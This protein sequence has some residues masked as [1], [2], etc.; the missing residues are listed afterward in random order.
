MH[1]STYSMWKFRV[2]W[3]NTRIT[4]LQII[5]YLLNLSIC[6]YN[7]Y[8][9]VQKLKSCGNVKI[10]I[11]VSFIIFCKLLFLLFK[12]CNIYELISLPHIYIISVILN[13]FLFLLICLETYHQIINELR[14]S[15]LLW[16]NMPNTFNEWIWNNNQS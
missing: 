5:S 14:V 10:I 15:A 6:N 9:N 7:F 12:H 2:I 11:V 4:V 13:C 1:C 16:I 8:Q 3:L